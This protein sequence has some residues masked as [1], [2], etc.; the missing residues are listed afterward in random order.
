M[1]LMA[2]FIAPSNEIYTF[3]KI[4]DFLMSENQVKDLNLSFKSL[5]S[6]SEQNPMSF[7]Y[8]VTRVVFIIFIVTRC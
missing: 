3:D 8:Q 1:Y 5:V 7:L 2:R 4:D 6:S